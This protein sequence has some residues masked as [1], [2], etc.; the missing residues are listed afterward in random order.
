MIIATN[1][2]MGYS[3]FIVHLLNGLSLWFEFRLVNAPLYVLALRR[4]LQRASLKVAS[5][6]S[7]LSFWRKKANKV[8]SAEP[9]GRTL[10]DRRNEAHLR[11]DVQQ[12]L[13]ALN[14]QRLKRA[15]VQR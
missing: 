14:N 15:P 3:N 13:D 12:I 7:I 1:T 10:D 9:P 4:F 5:A 6:G 2:E 11:A 8:R